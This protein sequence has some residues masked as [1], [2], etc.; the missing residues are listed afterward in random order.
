MKTDCEYLRK[1]DCNE[2]KIR[3]RFN[4]FFCFPKKCADIKD[5]YFKLDKERQKQIDQ[6]LDKRQTTIRRLERQ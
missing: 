2:G 4:D 1:I 3:C 5:C 6:E